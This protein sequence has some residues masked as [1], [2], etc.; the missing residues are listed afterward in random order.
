[1]GFI[2]LKK[3]SPT[4]A[5]EELT[6]AIKLSPAMKERIKNHDHFKPLRD[7]ADFQKIVS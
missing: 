5:V 7:R 3:Q 1:L 2:F 6:E 4:K